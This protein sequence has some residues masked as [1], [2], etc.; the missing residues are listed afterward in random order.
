MKITVLVWRRSVPEYQCHFSTDHLPLKAE[1]GST[2]CSI[3]WPIAGDQPYNT[4][5]LSLILH[6][7][8]EL[9]EVRT[10][11]MGL[12][13]LYRT[14]EA[15]RATVQAVREDARL[16]LENTHLGLMAKS[17]GLILRDAVLSAW[18]SR[19]SKRFYRSYPSEKRFESNG[20]RTLSHRQ[21]AMIV[22]VVGT[23][24]IACIVF[25]KN[26]CILNS[27]IFPSMTR[28]CEELYHKCE[29]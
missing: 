17:R 26:I 3:C 19:V 25:R 7:G 15:P 12:Q 6:V 5:R 11:E 2:F 23:L 29:Q 14:N 1:G 18:A 27:G 13:P 9:L 21:T 10:G 4:T 24:S 16:V 8:Y 22:N 28:Y 20:R